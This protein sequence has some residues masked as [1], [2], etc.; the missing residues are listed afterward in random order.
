MNSLPVGKL[1]PEHLIRI[2]SQ[3]PI[4][5][6]RVIL[7]PGVGLDCA[8]VE[9]GDRYLVLK[10]DPITFATDEIGWYAVQVNA[11]DVAT[12]GAKPSWM[13]VTALLPEGATSPELVEEISQQLFR[14]CQHMEISVVGGHTE[15]TYGL[16]RPILIA[17][18]IG[19]VERENLITPRGAK[20][21]DQILITKGVPIEATAIL[22]REFP[23]KLAQSLE[24]E[25]INSA[26]NYLYDPGISVVLEASIAARTGKVTAMHDPTEGG[27]I[28][29]LWELSQAC[30]QA[31]IFEPD[32]VPIPTLSREICKIFN[33]DPLAAIASGALLLTCPPKDAPEIFAALESEAI[34][35]ALIGK[36]ETGSV[37]LWR[38]KPGGREAIP[39]PEQDEI[40]KVYEL[41]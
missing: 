40:A 4:S 28:G 29:A 20:P 23:Q 9:Y 10:S 26:K 24:T 11:N 33:I 35:C 39:L 13:L 17:T 25:E 15:I 41:D 22:A 3:A 14:A 6:E 32:D 31:I 18:L 38:E 34:S 36:I 19:E 37:G 27:L 5:D 16:E 8:V 1:P 12:T 30:G 7:G 21:G 2:L